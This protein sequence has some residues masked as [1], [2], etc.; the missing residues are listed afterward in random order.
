MRTRGAVKHRW[1][2]PTVE[3]DAWLLGGRHRACPP[4]RWLV[5]PS[6]RRDGLGRK[7]EFDELE[8]ARQLYQTGNRNLGMPG[9]PLGVP[10]RTV[11]GPG[12]AGV[13]AARTL[14]ASS[15]CGVW[16][17]PGQVQ[18]RR[19]A[20]GAQLRRACRRCGW[21]HTLLQP[22][23]PIGG[24]SVSAVPVPG[25]AEPAVIADANDDYYGAL[26]R[27]HYRSSP[28]STPASH[29][30]QREDVERRFRRAGRRRIHVCRAHDPGDGHRL[31]TSAVVLASLP[32]RPANYVQRAGRAGRANA[33]PCATCWVG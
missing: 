27:G 17:Q 15:C 1:L 22:C 30:R 33:T 4:S 6:V 13:L 28:M 9:R 10:G 29:P 16:F 20:G 19:W 21:Q 31:V 24:W 11:P 8:S 23:W 2:A 14:G 3:A 7:S 32:K 26:P 12:G 5:R 18:V 25:P